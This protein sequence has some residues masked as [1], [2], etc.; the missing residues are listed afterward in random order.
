MME[1]FAGKI[2]RF[3]SFSSQ[4]RKRRPLLLFFHLRRLRVLYRATSLVRAF[5]IDRETD[6]GRIGSA[7]RRSRCT[8]C[9]FKEFLLRP[10]C[11]QE[12]LLA[13]QD[14]SRRSWE[15]WNGPSSQSAICSQRAV[16]VPRQ[17]QD[18]S[19]SAAGRA[20]SHHRFH[21]GRELHSVTADD[22]IPPRKIPAPFLPG[23]SSIAHD[24][25]GAFAMTARCLRR[26]ASTVPHE[27]HTNCLL[28]RY[29]GTH[30]GYPAPNIP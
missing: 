18:R 17:S 8:G 13:R 11:D 7:E 24:C 12:P 15:N 4:R 1:E 9:V 26:S 28:V 6:R 21:A 25:P 19:R 27:A 14:R 16:P 20:P 5:R 29:G 22:T 23:Q 10:L 30:V 3:K 2:G